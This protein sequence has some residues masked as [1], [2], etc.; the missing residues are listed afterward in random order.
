MIRAGIIKQFHQCVPIS[1]Y[2]VCKETWERRH[3]LLSNPT[4]YTATTT[5]VAFGI[6][7]GGLFSFLQNIPRSTSVERVHFFACDRSFRKCV[8]FCC[9]LAEN[10]NWK[11]NP[12][13][14]FRYIVR[15]QIIEVIHISKS[16]QK[17]YN[18]HIWCVGDLCDILCHVNWIINNQRFNSVIISECRPFEKPLTLQINI[19]RSWPII[20]LRKILLAMIPS[21]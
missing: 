1:F 6:A 18:A 16:F 2:R 17:H 15:H 12:L 8:T 7:N 14:D 5:S 3:T 13:N 11:R 19:S 20:Y 9:I 10:R 4:R 21:I